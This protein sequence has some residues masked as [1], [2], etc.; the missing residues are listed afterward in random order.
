MFIYYTGRRHIF[1][2][3]PESYVILNSPPQRKRKLI[4]CKVNPPE[5]KRGHAQA[6]EKV[7]IAGWRLDGK[8]GPCLQS[9]SCSLYFIHKTHT[10]VGTLPLVRSKTTEAKK[11]KRLIY[12]GTFLDP[13]TMG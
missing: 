8:L 13:K 3:D 6:K 9:S 1:I 7:Y 2:L 4:N 5:N 11:K 10:L 12:L